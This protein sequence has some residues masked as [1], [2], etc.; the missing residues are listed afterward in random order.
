MK[1]DEEGN[2][3]GSWG[4]RFEGGAHGFYLHK[5]AKGDYLYITDTGEG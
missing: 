1:F 5:E 4:E 2:Y 3:L